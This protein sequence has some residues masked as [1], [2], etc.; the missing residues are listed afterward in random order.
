MVIFAQHNLLTDP[1]FTRVDLV[2]CRNLLIYFE[3]ALQ[4]RVIPS[5][6]YA[7]KPSGYLMLGAS[8]TVGQ[9]TNFFDPAEKAHKIFVRKAGSAGCATKD[10]RRCR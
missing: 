6:H 7:L 9:F 4:Q 3:P 5:F 2:T 1:P 8:E 10:R